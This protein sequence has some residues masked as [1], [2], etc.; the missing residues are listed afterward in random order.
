MP[1][2]TY[3][4][5]DLNNLGALYTDLS[6]HV[7]VESLLARAFKISENAF[8]PDHRDV[9]VRLAESFSVERRKLMRFLGAKV[10]LT[11]AT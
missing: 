3:V 10:V 9:G 8:G 5:I 1:I 6:R 2:D 7:E 4:G 11:P